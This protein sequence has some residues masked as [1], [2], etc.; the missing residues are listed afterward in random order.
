MDQGSIKRLHGVVGHEQS[1]ME[2]RLQNKGRFEGVLKLVLMGCVKR[3]P[4]LRRSGIEE[5]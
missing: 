4:C 1:E 3:A 2:S 5:G